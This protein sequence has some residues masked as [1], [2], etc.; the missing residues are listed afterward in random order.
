MDRERMTLG[1]RTFLEGMGQGFPGDEQEKTPERVA[2][3]WVE[4]LVSGYAMDPAA[5]LT[6]GRV[7][8]GSG[9]VMVRDVSFRVER[10]F[11]SAKTALSSNRIFLI[12]VLLPDLI[13]K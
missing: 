10:S 1:I 13:L 8:E 12:R 3:A 4:D 11:R 6:W 7:P 2:R 5:L 9:P